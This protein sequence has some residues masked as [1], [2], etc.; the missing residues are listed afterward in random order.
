MALHEFLERTALFKGV[1]SEVFD[2]LATAAR[3]KT[4]A[5]G[6]MIWRVGESPE[7]LLL[8]KSGLVKLTRPAARGRTSLCGLFGAPTILGELVLVK[9]V[10]Y[11]N[12]AIPGTANVVLVSIPRELVLSAVHSDP[13]LALNLFCAFEQKFTALHDKIDVLSAGSVEARL[14]TLLLKLYDQ[15]GDELDDGSLRI[16]VP[17]SRQEL[18]DM[19]ST[20]F[21]TAIRV[22]ARW[23]REGTVATDG[24]G[25]TIGDLSRLQGLSGAD[26]SPSLSLLEAT[27]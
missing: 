4:Y 18:A 12:A 6:S 5:R 19:V 26:W 24:D 23:E 13:Q 27:R 17:L 10:P 9:G 3:T 14:A 25:F 7:A 8:V 15:F 16:G 1:D 21:E 20:S 22:L 11:Q 2:Q